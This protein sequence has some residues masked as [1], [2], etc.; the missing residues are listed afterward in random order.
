[1]RRP[2]EFGHPRVGDDV[3]LAAAALPIEDPREQHARVA[4]RRSGRA[5]RSAR[6]SSGGPRCTITPRMRRGPVP[7]RRRRTRTGS[8]PPIS[9]Y[10]SGAP[11]AAMSLGELAQP[12][13]RRP[14][15]ARASR[16]ATRRACRA[17]GA[18][19]VASARA[20]APAR[21]PRRAECRTCGPRSPVAMYACGFS[22]VTSGLMR[23]PT[24]ATTPSS[25]ATASSRCSSA[26]DSTLISFTPAS[27]ASR[28]SC[29][30]LPTPPKMMSAPAE[31]RAQRPV[32]ARRR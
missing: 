18:R 27:S 21:A 2:E 6:R 28:S 29:S 31:S 5:R 26:S 30:V 14:G 20:D 8:P 25:R 23:N 4:P 24:G 3:I 7:G 17:R 1:M 22:T 11:R 32:A 12:L 13:E 9:T 16:A 15:R 19:R 10:R